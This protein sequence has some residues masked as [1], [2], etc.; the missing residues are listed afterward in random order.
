MSP[1]R[2]PLAPLLPRF[3][4]AAIWRS[5]KCRWVVKGHCRPR[6]ASMEPRFGDRGNMFSRYMAD[7][8]DQLQWSRDL[9]IA[10]ITVTLPAGGSAP[11]FNGAA[12]WRSRKCDKQLR[13]IARE[14]RA[15]MEPRF[16][17]RGNAFLSW[18]IDAEHLALQWSRDLEIAEMS[19]TAGRGYLYALASMEPRFGDRGNRGLWHRTRI[20]R[21]A[22][23]EPR[24][25]DRGNTVMAHEMR[26]RTLAS[27]EPRFGDRGNLQQGNSVSALYSLQWS[28]DLE[29]AEMS[30]CSTHVSARN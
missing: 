2:A 18:D 19:V 23:M 29:I 15:S 16:G 11:R 30:P 3:N 24:F 21:R 25:G 10:E 1:G 13:R 20:G 4:G 5:R 22:S 28:R 6:T 8:R 7:V 27:M 9:E 17:D 12:I 26:V 14:N